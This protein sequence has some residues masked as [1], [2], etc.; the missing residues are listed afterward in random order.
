MT[1]DVWNKNNT[2][3]DAGR[4]AFDVTVAGHTAEGERVTQDVFVDI[5]G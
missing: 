5:N 3:G 2:F 1:L 4:D